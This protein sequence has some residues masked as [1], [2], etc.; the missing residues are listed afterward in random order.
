MNRNHLFVYPNSKFHLLFCI[1]TI[2]LTNG[3]DADNKTALFTRE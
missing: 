3:I 1:G 2:V